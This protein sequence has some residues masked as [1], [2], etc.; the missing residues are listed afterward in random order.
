MLIGFYPYGLHV[1]C[2]HLYRGKKG[3]YFGILNISALSWENG[4]ILQIKKVYI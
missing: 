4:K 2:G 1:S 3:L